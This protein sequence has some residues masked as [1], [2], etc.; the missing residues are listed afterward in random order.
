MLI[1]SRFFVFRA[2]YSPAFSKPDI[3][4]LAL[5]AT[6]CFRIE[7]QTNQIN[8]APQAQ[9]IIVHIL[10]FKAFTAL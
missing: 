8:V 10:R 9:P 4:Q 6:N 5:F 3:T 7:P 1:T 2:Y